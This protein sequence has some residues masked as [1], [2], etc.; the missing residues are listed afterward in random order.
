METDS[1]ASYI[2]KVTDKAKNIA[3]ICNRNSQ[4]FDNIF[5]DPYVRFWESNKLSY[6]SFTSAN[7][8]IEILE[9][10]ALSN[11]MKKDQAFLNERKKYY[12]EKYNASGE[13]T[14]SNSLFNEYNKNYRAKYK[15]DYYDFYHN[16]TDNLGEKQV[17][18]ALYEL[19]KLLLENPKFHNWYYSTKEEIWKDDTL[20][21]NQKTIFVMLM[22]PLKNK[23]NS[24]KPVV[25]TRRECFDIYRDNCCR[26]K[27][28]KKDSFNIDKF[29]TMQYNLYKKKYLIN[30]EER[31]DEDNFREY[32]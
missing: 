30:Y 20:T 10:V 22:T 15:S 19:S 1:R 5:T 18:T 8:N 7:L 11:Y 14:L 9:E 24:K 17:V 23:I 32:M 3:F 25:M 31:Q 29:R 6:M 4:D 26:L 12:I 27:R 13:Y 2:L 28:R 16:L 21:L